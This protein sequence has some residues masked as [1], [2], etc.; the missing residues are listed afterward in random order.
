MAMGQS[1]A[2]PSMAFTKE[3]MICLCLEFIAYQRIPHKVPSWVPPQ[4]GYRVL[5][6][7]WGRILPSGFNLAQGNILELLQMYWGCSPL[8]F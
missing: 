5:D 2:L 4:R 3:E 1:M 7:I 8:P 6:E